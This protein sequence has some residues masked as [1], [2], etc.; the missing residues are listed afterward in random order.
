MRLGLRHVPAFPS[1]DW[2]LVLASRQRGTARTRDSIAE[3]CA[4]YWYPVY[5]YLR[6]RGH[7]ADEAEDLTQGFFAHLLTQRLLA[8][9]QPEKGRLRSLILASLT[10]FVANE[11]DR[12]CAQKRRGAAHVRADAVDAEARYAREPADH[13]TPERLYERQWAATL[14]T[15]VL[16]R[17]RDEVARSGKDRAFDLL[18]GHLIG[19][20]DQAAYRDAAEALGLSAGAVRVAVHRLRRR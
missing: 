17:L 4:V 16:D 15:R 7:G 11:H 13:V 2:R 14:L 18:K 8:R 6:R 19:E 9:A 12:R 1:T 10:N 3:L 20:K 5:A